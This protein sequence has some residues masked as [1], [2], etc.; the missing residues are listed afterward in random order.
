MTLTE[1]DFSQ[2]YTSGFSR[3]QAFLRSKGL[4]AERAEEL[5]QAAWTKGWEARTQLHDS[6]SVLAWVNTI[7]FNLFRSELRTSKRRP[8]LDAAD[9]PLMAKPFE[10]RV[11]ARFDLSRLMKD[12][13]KRDFE[14]IAR[15]YL[16][17]ESS[18]EI[19][20]G[21]KLSA[22]AVRLRLHRAMTVLRTLVRPTVPANTHT[23]ARRE[24]VT[25]HG[26]KAFQW[27]A[28]A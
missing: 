1:S 24:E 2:S 5:A 13:R 7:A 8:Q 16:Q 10:P 18:R 28:A 22:V 17:G 27:K 12:L 23:M 25:Q 11:T 26:M 20:R 3:T 19:S 15:C 9:V 14:L 6:E 21:A 4:S